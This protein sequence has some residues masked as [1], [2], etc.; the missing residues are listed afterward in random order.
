[1]ATERSVQLHGFEKWVSKA[2]E[3][4]FM[5]TDSFSGHEMGASLGVAS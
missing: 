4:D 2:A 5:V 1:M 3:T